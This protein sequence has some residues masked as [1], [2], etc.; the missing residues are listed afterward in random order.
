MEQLEDRL[1]P[2][3]I[4]IPTNLTGSPGGVVTVPINVDTLADLVGHMGL[5]GADF[6]V[7]YDPNVF[8]VSAVADVKLGTI[9]TGGSLAPGNGYTP[10]PPTVGA[11]R[12]RRPLPASWQSLWPT[13]A[14]ESSPE[15]AAA[16]W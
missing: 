10:M 11:S 16:A 14:R 15:S 5:S 7:N 9:F 3:Q 8:G 4:S 2:T 1:V 12:Q 6:V 13:A